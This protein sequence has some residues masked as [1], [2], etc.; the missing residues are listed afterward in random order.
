MIEFVG[1]GSRKDILS[2]G[3][4]TRFFQKL[5]KKGRVLVQQQHIQIQPVE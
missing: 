1:A 3:G 4:N 5:R 2:P